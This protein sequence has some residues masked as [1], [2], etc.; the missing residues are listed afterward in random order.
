MGTAA[1]KYPGMVMGWETVAKKQMLLL[2]IREGT[3]R[4]KEDNDGKTFLSQM[5]I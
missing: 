1:K 3:E 4:R 2:F 5:L